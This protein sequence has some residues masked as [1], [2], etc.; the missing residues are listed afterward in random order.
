[1]LR[2]TFC[3]IP[4]I[5]KDSERRLWESGCETWED[6][7]GGRPVSLGS[8]SR[9]LVLRQVEASEKALS[10]GHHQFFATGLGRNLS[11]RA[12]P[13]FGHSTC[14]LD[15]ETD[16]GKGG[17][18]VT[19]IGIYDEEGFKC[20]VKGDNLGNFPDLISHY[21][22]VVTFYGSMFDVPML[23]KCF[24]GLRMDQIHLDLCFALKDLGFKGG[25]KKIERQLGIVRPDEVEG[26]DGYEAIRLW[27]AHL[28]GSP[29]AL[30]TL[31][32]YNREDV[33]NLPALAQVAYD[34]LR[35]ESLFDTIRAS[36]SEL[37]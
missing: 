35:R 36:R 15:I 16:G 30:E 4:G 37:A 1:M 28:A 5:G 23:E 8:A 27:R 11:W 9:E 19:M 7:L 25:L 12:W 13:E 22:M 17:S 34:G 14:Y 33:A 32:A 18:A 6:V 26:L 2:N 31:I 21:S 29:T 3:H 10:E 20:L 24:H